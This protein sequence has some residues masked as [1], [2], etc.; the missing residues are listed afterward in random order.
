MDY[1]G[2]VVLVSHVRHL[3]TSTC[4][5]LWLVADG[6]CAEFEGDLADY[7]KWLSRRDTTKPPA[8]KSDDKPSAKD[9]RRNASDQREQIRPLKDALKK[10]DTQMARLQK[11]LAAVEQKIADPAMYETG[12]G[13]EVAKL[14]RD[15]G[16]LKKKLA[17]AEEEWLE[18][19]E[20]LEALGV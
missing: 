5:T 19:T 15:Q 18:A 17:A 2:A 9:Q 1:A 10:L 12:G 11:E 14:T 8:P 4:E 13:A 6:R 3:L 16:E 20:K 7:A